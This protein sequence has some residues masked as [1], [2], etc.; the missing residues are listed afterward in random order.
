VRSAPAVFRE[1]VRGLAGDPPI[2]LRG[3]P[4][5][6]TIIAALIGAYA[7]ALL[8][9]G[10]IASAVLAAPVF[11]AT[12]VLSGPVALVAWL[13]CLVVTIT[14]IPF[15]ELTRIG[16]G[17]DAPFVLVSATILRAIVVTAVSSQT[18]HLHREA[19][20]AR[21]LDSVLEITERLANTH[22]RPT[23]LR[24]IV[25]ETLRGLEADATV[26]RLVQGDRLEV[27]AWAG[28][29]DATA[30]RLPVF[31]KG[32]AWFGEIARTGKPWVVN[33]AQRA[34]I[35]DAYDRYR[36]VFDFRG[37]IIV[38]LIH[39]GTVIGSLS[40]VTREP[41]NWKGSDVA[42]V[43]ALGTH[44]AIALE[45][46]DLIAQTEQRAAQLSVLQ[47]ASARLSRASGVEEVGRAIVEETGKII[48]YH[49]ARVYQLDASG[50]VAPIAF[51][52]SVGAYEKVDFE[53]LR[54]S[55]G[56]GFTGWVAQFG[57]PLL[58]NDANADPRGEN[59]AGTED[60]D[61]SMLVVPMRYDAKV[62]GVI[63]L[64]KLGLNQFDEEDQRLL[65]IL[66]DQAATA[67]ESARLLARS[68]GLAAELRRL[69]DMSGQLSASLESRQVANIIARHLASALGV[70][71]CA[72]SYWD[73]P[74]GRLATLGYFPE[75]P[76]H[77]LTP[78]YDISG[79]PQSR[80]V[81]EDQTTEIVYVDD[82]AADP[83]ETALLTREGYR[84]LVMLPLVAKGQ[85]IG[86]VELISFTPIN[87]DTEQLE[88]ARTMANEA[89][90]AL[91]NARLYEEA[92]ALADRDQLTGF[93]NH[94]YLH[95]R[96]GEEVIR[97]Q[98]SR[99]PLSVLMLDLDDFKL[100]NDTFGHL[101]GDQVL[102]WIA[103]VIRSTLRASDIPAR[104]GGD[105]FA[106]LLP[107]T[108]ADAAATAADRIRD[109]FASATFDGGSRRQVAVSLAVG[110]ATYP[111]DGRSATELIAV[112]DA[113]LYEE[114]RRDEDPRPPR[115]HAGSRRTKHVGAV[116]SN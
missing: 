50:D 106:I 35:G 68:Q 14:I 105:E 23:L 107:D 40:G 1:L 83:A 48:D 49:N 81:L 53:L 60:V 98:R 97:T 115:M 3:G 21:R 17:F 110:A 65:L 39:E 58:I 61:E 55:L 89:A 32:E 13:V 51:E 73:R 18:D 43:S 100:V 36:G 66:A 90:M 52:G 88:L 5:A 75:L 64:S 101:F 96:F 76:G 46:S 94:R 78:F 109:A 27:V 92:R 69:L 38:P 63:T 113:R 29:D 104:Y 99:Q 24:A 80:R 37:D 71:E 86:L 34:A 25:D 16:N 42:F 114:K 72:I 9:F 62:I 45:N 30:A 28:L 22:D 67:L 112:A 56:V 108:T 2:T 6:W 70:D 74:N 82:P 31:S 10:P 91:E 85:S 7:V 4:P 103:E 15:A 54:T 12:V 87:L 111:T 77:E 93:Y 8:T 20:L 41:R 102:A 116:R 84:S 19:M 26:L 33:D 11:I 44:A 57:V 95:E 47:A 79:F 59:I